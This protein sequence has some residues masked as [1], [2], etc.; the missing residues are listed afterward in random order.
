MSGRRKGRR[1]GRVTDGDLVRGQRVAE[2][3]LGRQVPLDDVEA[4]GGRRVEPGVVVFEDG[5]GGEWI[6]TGA[7]GR[8]VRSMMTQGC[9]ECA[10]GLAHEG[11]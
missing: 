8:R 9:P 1:N 5:R 7:T 11:H 3:M 6:L 2:R 4:V 10:A